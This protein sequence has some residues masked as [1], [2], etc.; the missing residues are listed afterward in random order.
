MQFRPLLS[1]GVMVALAAVLYSQTPSQNSQGTEQARGQI[2]VNVVEVPLLV[3][4]TDNK[5]KLITNLK[6]EDFRVYEDD[7]LQTI[8]GFTRETD[9]PLSIALLVDSSGSIIDKVKFEQAAATDFFFSTVKRG[10][11][12]AMVIT[13]DSTASILTDRTPDHFTDEPELLAEAVRKIRAGGGSAVYDALY[14]AVQKKLALEQR[15]RRRLIVLISDGDDNASRYS[16]TEALE[17]TQRNDTTIYAISTNKT[18]DTKSRGKVTGDDV[19]QKMV[20][21][22]GG[23]AYFPLKLDD[24]AADFQKIG[25][26]LRSQ[27]VISYT[28]TNPSL[29]GTYREIKIEM[30][31]KKYKART[32]AGYFAFAKT[33]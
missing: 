5:G 7:K 6:K 26:E 19:I 9:L 11:D 15:D 13:F 21:E 22:T 12:R 30:G 32:R 27:Y 20:D 25:D 31:D 1:I 33:N 2:G 17:M 10:K 16:L 14:L 28:P 29:D 8:G 24:L 4:V 3:S 23:K 18:S